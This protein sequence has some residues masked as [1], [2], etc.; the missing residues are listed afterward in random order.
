[1]SE[2]EKK[3]LPA[4]V[5]GDG[6]VDDEEK[7]LYMEFKRRELEDQDAMRDSQVKYWATWQPHILLLL[8][9]S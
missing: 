8:L 5:N 9:V 6:K 7:K 2:E 1:M 3:I 4:D